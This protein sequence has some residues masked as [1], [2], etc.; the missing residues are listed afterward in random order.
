MGRQLPLTQSFLVAKIKHS[1]RSKS[2]FKINLS[3]SI[4]LKAQESLCPGSVPKSSEGTYRGRDLAVSEN[5]QLLFE[6][7]RVRI[8]H[9]YLNHNSTVPS[10]GI[11]DE[12]F[13]EDIWIEKLVCAHPISPWACQHPQEGN[14]GTTAQREPGHALTK[15]LIWMRTL[16]HAAILI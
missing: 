16:E 15:F 8:V 9:L 3:N 1:L 5:M 12:G 4:I 11:P 6:S 10:P 13:T 14:S 7:L 2:S